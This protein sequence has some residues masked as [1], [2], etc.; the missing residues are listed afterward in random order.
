MEK[1]TIIG[2]DLAKRVFQ[3]HAASK[4]GR[5][6]LRKKVSRAQL[7]GFLAKQPRAIVAMEACA[8]AHEWGRAISGL[9]HD[10]RLIPPIYVKPFVRR[11]K[12]DAADAEAIAEAA[13]RPT[14]RFVAVKTEE[15]QARSMIFRT[16]DLLVRQ[17]TQ[18]VNALRGH[19]AEHG[20][21]AA[22]GLAKVKVLAA[23]LREAVEGSVHPLVRELGPVLTALMVAGRNS[24]G[25]ASESLV[26]SGEVMRRNRRE[27]WTLSENAGIHSLCRPSGLLSRS[28]E[29]LMTPFRGDH[30]LGQSLSSPAPRVGRDVESLA[31]SARPAQRCIAPDAA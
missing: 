28:P 9:G 6:V 30:S 29:C 11:Q 21:V 10:V 26:M 31:R 15:Q 24:S 17:R 3:V 19:L 16:R 2:I 13:S 14:M 7:L 23:A 27:V 22:Q 5:P 1:A 18:L 12:N 25:I 8:T 20:I 4:D